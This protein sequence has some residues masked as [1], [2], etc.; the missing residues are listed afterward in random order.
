MKQFM[1]TAADLESQRTTCLNQ[2]RDI[3]NF[4]QKYQLTDAEVDALLH[5]PISAR[6]ETRHAHRTEEHQ[7]QQRQQSTSFSAP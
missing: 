6:D 1:Q 3:Q 7:Q 2:A 4:L 5:A